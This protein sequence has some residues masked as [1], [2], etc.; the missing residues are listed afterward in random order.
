MSPANLIV[1]GSP[2]PSS[3]STGIDLINAI[4]LNMEQNVARRLGNSERLKRCQNLENF[5]SARNEWFGA[6]HLFL[7]RHGLGTI[8]NVGAGK[9]EKL[10]AYKTFVLE[11]LRLGDQP[12]EILQNQAPIICAL[13]REGDVDFFRRMGHAFRGHDRARRERAPV[14]LAWCIALYWFAGLLWLMDAEA[15]HRALI[16]YLKDVGTAPREIVTLD[17]YK[18]ACSRLRL[19]GYRAFATRPPVLGYYPKQKAYGYR[20]RWTHLE[21][22]LSRS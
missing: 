12:K 13:A 10:K 21:P 6:W 20:K 5:A 15:G 14:D 1:G 2:D 18:K 8:L 3:I 11:M 17:A 7:Q 9:Q 16:L 19:K 22:A 4:V